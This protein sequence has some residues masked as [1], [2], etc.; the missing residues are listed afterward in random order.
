[1]IKQI[2]ITA[3]LL[4]T[5]NTNIAVAKKAPLPKEFFTCWK[6][7]HEEKDEKAKTQVFRPCTNEFRPSMF[8]LSIEFF[9]D[10]KCKYLHA[11]AT[12]AHY[13]VDG[14][15]SY[16]KRKKIITVF[17]DKKKIE[18]RFKVIEVKGDILKISDW[19]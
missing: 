18:Y 3:I 5:V 14:K 10:G 9:A 2:I 7:A 19:L 1:M 16:N 4:I 11:G 15:W 12:D 8:R 6:S 13:F 17:D